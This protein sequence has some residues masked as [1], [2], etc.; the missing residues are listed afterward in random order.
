M[1]V[2]ET[3]WFH[4]FVEHIF[5]DTFLTVRGAIIYVLLQSRQR[6]PKILLHLISTVTVFILHLFRI[7]FEVP[8]TELG[9]PPLI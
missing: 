6:E 3:I 5:I 8:K 9:P 2:E 1:S 7:T 4:C